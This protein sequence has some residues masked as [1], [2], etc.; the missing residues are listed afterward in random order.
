LQPL[1][2]D[3][4][5]ELARLGL[6]LGQQGRLAEGLETLRRA[7]IERPQSAELHNH[8]GSA[9]QAFG[10]ADLARQCYQQAIA[11]QDDFASAHCN[12]G[13]LLINFG[14]L[15][16]ALAHLQRAQQL[17]P[18]DVNRL[19]MVTSLPLIYASADDLQHRRRRLESNVQRLVDEGFA[20]DTTRTLVGTN[21]SAVYQGYNDRD[22]QR[23][24]GR[25]Y[26]APR[27]VAGEPR[28]AGR[29]RVGFLS[30]LFRNHTI[31]R[32]NLGRVALVDREQFEV[33]AILPGGAQ[34]AVAAEFRRSAEHC[35]E[36][37][38]G[39]EDVRRQIAD[40]KLDVLV[41]A[42]VGMHPLT[43]TLAQS[44]MAPIQCATWGHPVTTGSTAIDYFLSSHLLETDEADAHYTERL[45][46]LAN[47]G[48]YYYR[49]WLSIPPRTRSAFGLD[50]RR[51]V[52][53]CAQTLFKLHPDFDS[54]LAGILRRDDL[55]EVVLLEGPFPEWRQLIIERF[56]RSMPD[57]MP[58][59]RFLPVLP[60]ADFLWLCALADV[61]LDPLYFGGGN[62][63]Y[64]GLAMGTP[65]VTLPGQFLRGRITAALYQKMHVPDCVV[66]TS[67]RY[68]DLA[69]RLA[70]DSGYRATISAKI[71]NAAAALFE[72]PS[73]VREFERGL[74]W[75]AAGGRGEF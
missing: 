51:H 22:L 29:T 42:D 38:G 16:E 47:L 37:I 33:T 36:P 61:L 62:T 31:G 55:G 6:A 15:D 72:D 9:W 4:V 56:S 39:I 35:L 23:N 20:I 2:D 8:L 60:H 66:D 53:L 45:V 11:Y 25:I 41:F 74:A 26:R 48:T 59:V 69:V 70:T 21:F 46:R 3:G 40:L 58:R 7:V 12:L 54:I 14:L 49:P 19:Q 68:I 64:E 73:E 75:M 32:L 57:V 50:A 52:Y 30:T 63:S 67:E 65:I 44:R 27:M 1:S 28:T 24:L 5:A 34:D 17:Q 13:N 18:T 10:R 71:Q 43:Y